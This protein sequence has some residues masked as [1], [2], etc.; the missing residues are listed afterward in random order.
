[1]WAFRYRTTP[2]E[3]DYLEE[4]VQLLPAVAFHE[5]TYRKE[6]E[7]SDLSE[8]IKNILELLK[9]A[10]RV[11]KSHRSGGNSADSYSTLTR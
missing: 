1:M 8:I 11:F 4:I 2:Y 5:R 9:G 10:V 6:V 3:S 7:G